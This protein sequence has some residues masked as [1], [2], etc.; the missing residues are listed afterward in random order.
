MRLPLGLKAVAK[1][2]EGRKPSLLVSRVV[3]NE[4][5]GQNDPCWC[6]EWLKAKRRGRT[7]SVGV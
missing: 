3:E 1:K 7:L 2:G 4:E 6:Q 5:E